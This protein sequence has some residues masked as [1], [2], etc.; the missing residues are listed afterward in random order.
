MG[1]SLVVVTSYL[2]HPEHKKTP[3]P[4]EISIRRNIGNLIFRSGVNCSF[5]KFLEMI[6]SLKLLIRDDI[7]LIRGKNTVFR[8]T[9]VERA[10]QEWSSVPSG[11][12]ESV[13]MCFC[14]WRVRQSGSWGN[15]VV[16]HLGKSPQADTDSWM[17]R[18]T[19]PC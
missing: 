3:D 8:M 5:K 6:R 1:Y 18:S 13:S 2:S 16:G 7:S 14:R 9:E 17:S 11:C 4:F 19:V 12:I 15:Q 10:V